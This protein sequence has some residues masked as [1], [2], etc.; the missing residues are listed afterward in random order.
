MRKLWYKSEAGVWNEA[1][2]IG[3]GRLGAMV[4]GGASHDRLALNEETLWSGQPD[5]HSYEHNMKDIEQI[6]R[7]VKEK[8]YAEA[9]ERTARIMPGYVSEAYVPYGEIHIDVIYAPSE[10]SDYKRELDLER[11][12][13]TV[14]Y[15]LG[16]IKIKK[17]AFVSLADDVLVYHLKSSLPI[18]VRVQDSCE[19]SHVTSAASEI[20]KTV[21]RCPTHIDDECILS[22]CELDPSKESIPFAAMTRLI[23]KGDDAKTFGN[24]SLHAARLNELTVIL[25]LK[26]GFAGYNK[27]PMSEGRDFEAECKALLDRACEYSFEEL[28]SRH[29]AE[30]KKYF[31][32]VELKIEGENYDGEPTDERIKMAGEGRVDNGLVTLLFDYARYLTISGAGGTQPMNLQG[33]WNDRLIPPWHSNYTLNINTE[34]NYWHTD[35]C[36][37]GEFNLLLMEM[38]RELAER[39]NHFGLRGWSCFHNTDIWRFN[40]E[41]TS[42]PLWG[43]WQM[44]GFWLVRHIWEHYAHT[45]D[46]SFLTEYY[47]VLEGAVEF[48]ADWMY[49]DDGVLTVCPSTSPEN[50]FVGDGERSAVADGAAMDLEIILDV[51]DKTVKAGE[52]LGKDVSEYKKIMAKIKRPQ[53]GDDGR[54]L[55]WGEPLCEFEPGHR[56]ISH[57]Y[58]FYPSDILGD[59]YRDAVK[60]SLEFRLKN[61]GGHTG[62]SNAWIANVY[63]RLGDGEGVMRS[64]RTMFKRSIYPNMLDAHPP[65]Q[66]D[67]NF[68]ICAAIC[69][70]LLQS[71]SGEIKKLVALPAEWKHGEVR[72]FVARGGERVSFKW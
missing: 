14:E 44:G 16:D 58:G 20:I 29:E 45:C 53:I 2:P 32:R 66:I 3:N 22:V 12:V 19:L 33:I 34:M 30:Y 50:Y 1:L 49:E 23:A 64:I 18:E 71:H 36:D 48:L 7:L 4:F 10:L 5:T 59:E 39:G 11:G 25:S 13:S 47:P 72:G 27:K 26:T 60:K 17:T 62:W 54:L 28:L 35:I 8:R 38:I 15:K 41:A 65:F 57:L 6:R 51:F 52:I 24:S 37:L 67:G 43:F 69:E 42:Q 21:G 61:G 9:H 56:H 68:G 40:Y 31:E 70:A 46:K 63:A 55:E